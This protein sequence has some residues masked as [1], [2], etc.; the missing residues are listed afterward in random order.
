[1]LVNKIKLKTNYCINIAVKNNK[2]Q[3]IIPYVIQSL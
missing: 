2:L 3:I 1:M